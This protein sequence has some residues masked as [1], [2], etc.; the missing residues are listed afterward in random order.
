[1]MGELNLQGNVLPIGGLKEKILAAKQHGLKHLLGIAISWVYFWFGV[2]D[3]R[4]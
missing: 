1:M 3:L 4:R 2:S